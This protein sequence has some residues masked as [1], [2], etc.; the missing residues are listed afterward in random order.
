M[1][2][3]EIDLME[4]FFNIV[5]MQKW[6]LFTLKVRNMILFMQLTKETQLFCYEMIIHKVCLC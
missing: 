3:N 6:C 5:I 1:E 4:R 2:S